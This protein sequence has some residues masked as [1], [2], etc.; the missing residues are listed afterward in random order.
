VIEKLISGGQTGADIAALDVALKHDFPHGGWCPKGRRSEA[1][2]IPACYNVFETPSA[3]YLQRTERNVMHSDGTVVFT[4]AAKVTGGSLRTIEFARK[5]LKPCVHVASQG[6]FSENP[7]LRLQE[8]VAENGIKRLNVA[9]TRESKEPGIHQWVMQV[10]E[11]AFFCSEKYPEIP[12]GRAKV[13]TVKA[14]IQR[15]F[16]EESLPESPRKALTIRPDLLGSPSSP[17]DE[18]KNTNVK[19]NGSFFADKSLAERFLDDWYEVNIARAKEIS[20]EA[21][22]IISRH[23]QELRLDGLQRLSESAARCLSKHSGGYLSL[24]GLEEISDN[25][26]QFLAKHD[27]DLYLNGLKSISSEAAA[28]LSEHQGQLWLN[29]LIKLSAAEA[30]LIAE[31]RGSLRLDGVRELDDDAA[32]G[33]SAHKGDLNL[34]GLRELS[35]PA[36]RAFAKMKGSLH[37]SGLIEITEEVATELGKHQ[38]KLYLQGILKVSDGVA[39]AL[40]GNAG[41]L[42]LRGVASLSEKAAKALAKHRGEINLRGL[43]EA[44]PKG[45]ADLSKKKGTISGMCPEKWLKDFTHSSSP[46]ESSLCGD[47]TEGPNCVTLKR[48]AK[49][50]RKKS[51]S[52]SNSKNKMKRR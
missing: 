31:H 1:G 52:A 38:G 22:E 45:T 47:S 17:Q 33:L 44:P 34:R 46:P 40:S 25:A 18:Q 26:I 4:L 50:P 5:H 11:D 19:T 27:G 36:A 29:G 28:N 6:D 8:F 12:G 32:E 24:S 15:P 9:G 7:A 43:V 35:V 37:L 42:N 2:P 51:K 39:K 20:D 3:S 30:G 23:P 49:S 14:D 10:I 48:I 16:R 21:A 41:E 13:E